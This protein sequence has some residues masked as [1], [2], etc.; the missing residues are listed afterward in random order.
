MLLLPPQSRP[1]PKNPLPARSFPGVQ[2]IS[3][4]LL[5]HL[6]YISYLI[7]H[8]LYLISYILYLIITFMCYSVLQ[9]LVRANLLL[10]QKNSKPIA[11]SKICAIMSY[12]YAFL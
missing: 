9:W 8:I 12:V 6:S 10:E 5:P 3:G 2:L 7:S 4:W 11:K 1:P